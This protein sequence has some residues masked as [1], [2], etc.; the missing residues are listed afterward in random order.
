MMLVP[1]HLRAS[2]IHGLGVFAAAPI[3]K[4]TVLWRFQEGVDQVI[5][6]ALFETLPEVARRTI[7]YYAYQCPQFPGG[8]LLNFDNAR[9]LNHSTAPNTDNTTEVSIALRDIAEGEEITVDYDECCLVH[10]FQQ[11]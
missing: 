3:A 10:E 11:R 2:A 1:T 8:Y 5:P 7:D 6:F 9:F 4:G